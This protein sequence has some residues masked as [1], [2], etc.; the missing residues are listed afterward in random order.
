MK[1]TLRTT[2][3]T[4]LLAI[5][6]VLAAG[7][8]PARAQ[9]P[10]GGYGGGYGGNGGGYVPSYSYYGNAGHDYQPHGHTRQTPFGSYSYY[11]QGRH[12]FRPHPHVQTPYGI[13]G[14]SNGFFNSTQ[15]YSPPTPYGYRPW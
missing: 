12:D 4:G 14:Y 9:Y 8:S 3:L 1:L 13:T 10:Y 2:L 7:V 15:S 6:S 5:G 11:G